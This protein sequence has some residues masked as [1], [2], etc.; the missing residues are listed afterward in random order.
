MTS[1]RVR[2][3]VDRMRGAH[4]LHEGVHSS[5]GLLPYLL[6][7]RMIARLAVSIIQLIAVPVS[8]PATDLSGRRDHSLDQLLGDSLP[9]AQDVRELRAVGAHRPPLLLAARIRKHEVGPSA[10]CG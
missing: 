2:H 10:A 4:G 5:P 8:R 6:P 9:L 1:Q 7:E 3:A